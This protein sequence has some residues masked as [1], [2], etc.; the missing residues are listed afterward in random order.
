[1]KIAFDINGTLKKVSPEDTQSMLGFLKILKKA[2][3]YI[4]IW[5]GD[6]IHEIN[7]FISN[8]QLGPYVDL[9]V[10][11]L[12]FKQENLPDIAFDDSDFAYL[13]KLA[14]IKV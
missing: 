6:D 8:Y 10:S 11:K 3:H 14:T 1:M 7:Q 9:A 12:N 4:I 5:S 13:A 2:G